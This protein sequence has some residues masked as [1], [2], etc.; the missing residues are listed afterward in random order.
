MDRDLNLSSSLSKF[1][2]PLQLLLSL[3]SIFVLIKEPRSA[4]FFKNVSFELFQS[5]QICKESNYFDA[6]LL[7]YVFGDEN[8]GHGGRDID[9]GVKETSGGYMLIRMCDNRGGRRRLFG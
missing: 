7:L 5:Q 6:S 3:F 1:A 8:N 9:V 2:F 4:N